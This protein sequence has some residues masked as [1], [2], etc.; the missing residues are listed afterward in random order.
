LSSST[1]HF[2]YATRFRFAFSTLSDFEAGSRQ[3]GAQIDTS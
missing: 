3:Q 2:E 1:R